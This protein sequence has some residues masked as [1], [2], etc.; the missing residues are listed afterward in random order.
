MELAKKLYI[1]WI[2]MQKKATRFYQVA[3]LLFYFKKTSSALPSSPEG[4]S[5]R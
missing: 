1:S 5:P 3:I 2:I 4:A